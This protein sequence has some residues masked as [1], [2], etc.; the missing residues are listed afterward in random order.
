MQSNQPN[1]GYSNFD[2]LHVEKNGFGQERQIQYGYPSFE[3]SDNYDQGQ[4][5]TQS[6][7]GQLDLNLR[8]YTDSSNAI[9]PW[10]LQ[11]S[12][13][14][15]CSGFSGHPLNDFINQ[16]MTGSTRNN[17]TIPIPN[18]Q[19]LPNA[20]ISTLPIRQLSAFPTVPSV[21]TSEPVPV[22]PKKKQKR[23]PAQVKGTNIL[24][25]I[26]SDSAAPDISDSNH[27]ITNASNPLIVNCAATETLNLSSV[28]TC[29]KGPTKSKFRRQ[30]QKLSDEVMKGFENHTLHQLRRLQKTHVKYTRLNEEIKLAG[31]DLFF[32]YQRKLHLLSLRHQRPFKSLATYL[33]QR[34]TRQKK[35]LWHKFQSAG[36]MAQKSYH[37][38]QNSLAQRN[39][40]ASRSYKELDPAARGLYKGNDDDEWV[41]AETTNDPNIHEREQFNIRRQSNAK[42][43]AN[44]DTWAKGAQKKLKE[45]S[46]SMGI[47]GFLVIADQD[48]RQPYFFQGGSLFG[49]HFL[50]ELA[51]DGDPIRKFALC[52][53]VGKSVKGVVKSKIRAPVAANNQADAP[54]NTRSDGSKTSNADSSKANNSIKEPYIGR[55]ANLDVCQGKLAANHNYISAKLGEMLSQA[56]GMVG[57]NTRWPGTDTHN[58]LKKRKLMLKRHFSRP[59][60][61]LLIDE[62][63]IVLRGLKNN[64]ISLV[65]YEESQESTEFDIQQEMGQHK[66]QAS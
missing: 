65:P 56:I 30:D 45:F 12:S 33:G 17:S 27:P 29:T 15:T 53:A 28:A 23:Q 60:K 32:E 58:K 10:G 66:V 20:N 50:Q 38:T 5:F 59:I 42:L 4:N 63:W 46:D 6:Q 8:G 13:Q 35:S 39:K 47:E 48:H 40:D 61:T 36:Q 9:G 26:L 62:T 51:N 55:A 25:A 31:Q 2:Q 34:R 7:Q 16:Q 52:T 21:S 19:S 43:L 41:D 3:S 22:P 18:I 54:N 11:D 57:S 64:W 24:P 37:Q 14:L 1:Y 49:D 44:V